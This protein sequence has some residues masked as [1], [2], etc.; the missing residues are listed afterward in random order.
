M[1]ATAT[2]PMCALGAI[3]SGTAAG[4]VATKGDVS[5]ADIGAVSSTWI[6]LGADADTGQIQQWDSQDSLREVPMW[7]APME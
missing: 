3:A 6:A 1:G 2:K 5:D 7:R 4:L